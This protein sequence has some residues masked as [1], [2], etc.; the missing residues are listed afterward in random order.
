MERIKEALKKASSRSTCHNIRLGVIVETLRG[1]Y[2]LGWNGPPQRAGTHPACRMGG[3]LSP[4][5]VRNCPAVH[6]EIRAI[7]RAADRG[8]PIKGGT[9]YLSRWYPCAPCAVAIVEAG[10]AKLV[11]TEELN[12][13]FDDCF[14][15]RMA[16]EYLKAAGVI[17]EI[18]PELNPDNDL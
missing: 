8:V 11:L 13:E 5:N 7:C 2:V 18:K 10:I 15:F 14:N 17:V 4:E 3:S 16:R 12:L 1:E 6:A 9:L